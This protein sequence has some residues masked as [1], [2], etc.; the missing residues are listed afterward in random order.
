M[1]EAGVF[2]DGGDEPERARTAEPPLDNAQHR[3]R[4]LFGAPDKVRVLLLSG[5]TAHA[6]TI[7]TQ[8]AEAILASIAGMLLTTE[9]LVVDKPEEEE[10]EAALIESWTP[11]FRR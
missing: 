1:D 7:E 9:A 10:D 5:G 2:F 6:G 4:A 3:L 11:R 8:E